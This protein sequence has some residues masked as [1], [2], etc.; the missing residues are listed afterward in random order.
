[1]EVRTGS[2]AILYGAALVG[3]IAVST[4]LAGLRGTV[5]DTNAV[6]VLVL[7]VVAV[8]AA[9]SRSAG[10]VAALSC[11]VW[12]DF[13][14]TQ[15]YL[16]FTITRRDD[17]ETAV[18]LTAVGLAVTEIALWGRR[19][20]A[21]ASR[22]EGYLTGVVGAAALVAEGEAEPAVVVDFVRRQIMEVLG[23]DRCEFVPGPPVSRPRL[24]QD[25]SI[26][27]DGQTLDVDRA[28]LPTNDVIELPVSRGGVVL[29]R[30]VLTAAARVVWTTRE[31]RLVAVTLA[32]Q[33][34]AVL[35]GNQSEP[36]P[37]NLGR[38]P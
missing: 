4:A 16:T 1:M 3:P 37:G 34:A 13:F 29:G 28:G 35:S 5:H 10:I 7:V 32:D 11:A 21:R 19:Q 8:A 38:T 12:F 22:R 2:P 6:L 17:V 9:G 30:F 15:P 26:V 27:R 31:Q 14:L 18:L 24:I 33:A 25:G 20:Q 36:K 23:V